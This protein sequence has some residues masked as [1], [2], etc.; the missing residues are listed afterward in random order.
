MSEIGT[1]NPVFYRT[2]S[3]FVNGRRETW[4]DTVSRVVAAVAEMG[5]FTRDETELIATELKEMR[6]FCSGRSLWCIG[7]P[8]SQ[9]PENFPGLFNCN[10]TN[11]DTIEAFSNLMEFAMMG[12]GTGAVLERK[13]TEKLPPVNQGFEFE[14]I[15]S[16]GD[17]D[18]PVRK[19]QT[20]IKVY[21]N[22]NNQTLQVES[23]RIRIIV[24]DSRE[25]W[26]TA[27]STLLKI[28]MS[29]AVFQ[30]L[31]IKVDLS[32]VRP[33]GER[34]EGFGGTA[35]PIGLERM[36][37][38][39]A[40]ILNKAVGR[41][42]TPVECCRL[43]DE[44]AMCVVAG[45]IRR[46]AGMR[47]FDADNDEA[48]TVKQNL[49]FQ[50]SEGNWRVDPEKDAFR[51]A[52]HTR[53][54]HEKPTYAQVL[55]SITLQYYSGEGAIQYAPEAVRRAQGSDRYGLNPC[56]EI[57]MSNNFCNLSEV[58]LNKISPDD[59]KAQELAFKA[60]ALHVCALLQR[61]F[62]QKRYQ[63]SR[64][65][66]PIVGV[67]FTGLFDFFVAAFGVDWLKWWEQGRPSTPQGISFQLQEIHY[68]RSWRTVVELTVHDYCHRHGLKMPNRCTT[69]Q[70]AGCLTVDA[71]RVFDQGLLLAS[72]HMEPEA[73][74]VDVTEF[75]LSVR[76]GTSVTSAVANEPLK[77]VRVTLKNG[78]QIT[79]TPNHR[80]KVDGDWVRAD[81]LVV[82]KE[83]Y[84]QLGTY[85][86][87]NESYLDPIDLPTVAKGR[88]CK[89]CVLPDKTSPAL[90]YFMGALFANGHMS[91]H[92][93]R[94]RFSHGNLQILEKLSVISQMLF[95]L[96]GQIHSDKR[97]GRHELCL[98]NRQLFEWFNVNG[99]AKAGKS[100]DLAVIPLAIRTASAETLLH[101]FAGYIDCDGCIRK[102]GSLSIDSASEAFMRHLQQVGEALGLSFSLFHNTEGTNMQQ[103]KDMWGLCLSRMESLSTAMA[104]I[105]ATSVKAQTR[106]IP[107]PK[108]HF[109]F[110]PYAIE[111][112]EYG[113]ED[114]TYDYAV[115]GVD[116]DDS[117]Y[118]QGGL[119]SHNTKSLLTGASP[120]WHPPKAARYIRRITFGKDDPIAKAM[121]DIGYNVTPSQ[122]DT[123]DE[124][125]LLND[126]FDSRCKEWLVEIPVE[127]PWANLPGADKI[128]LSKFNIEAQFDFY[129]NV[130]RSYTTHNTSAT[131]ELRENEIEMLARLIHREIEDGGG[132]ISAAILARFDDLQ[133]YPRLPFEPISKTTYDELVAD[134]QMTQRHSP[135]FHT[136]LERYDRGEV[137]QV[138]PAGCDS[139]KCLLPE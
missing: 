94:I 76:Q 55:E 31:N 3:R 112:I 80:L 23:V 47:Q 81:D 45:N 16:P 36:F 51:M 56:G 124:G 79:M 53:V 18:K 67:S 119:V 103:S 59:E 93:Y 86:K 52:N 65:E 5:K 8:W 129:M 62:T 102:T 2:Y 95:G 35:N 101:F 25:G 99:L 39:V 17:I 12:V 82:G 139:D 43:I 20:E 87:S 38:R 113:I 111:S 33:M 130:Q 58:H 117:W 98:A 114:Y 41:Q 122:S 135:D 1:F 74:E 136:H 10:S 108:R 115:D 66:D 26:V 64:I 32:N 4:G 63:Q 24:G 6:S 131:L 107:L 120:G 9:K 28:A 85:R 54:F 42:L 71:V 84:H 48:A 77:L 118:F 22:P 137:G 121:M 92:K 91:E 15:G 123:D 13:Y 61:D 110:K 125:N 105:N 90:G 69:V 46:S 70:P 104:V 49:W 89:G 50:D 106:P 127:M 116:D 97:G 96:A 100:K 37:Y 133:T 88:P 11:V 44:A 34:L 57:I 83:V 134:I 19:H 68:L 30:D 21:G 132:Y 60:A 126:P 138:G 128:D 72:D 29:Q 27:Y 75:N 7:T 109:H 73:G 14:V 40:S 78:R